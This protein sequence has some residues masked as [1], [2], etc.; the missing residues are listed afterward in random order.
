MDKRSFDPE[1]Y[2]HLAAPVSVLARDFAKDDTSALHSH[3]RCQLIY[4]VSGTMRVSTALSTWIVPPQRALWI[5]P[6]VLHK[7]ERLDP[8]SMRTA[9]I[10]ADRNPFGP[11]ECHM[12]AMSSLVRELILR[13]LEEPQDYV[14]EGPALCAANLLLS[15]L[16]KLRKLD[17]TLPMPQ[18]QRLRR[19]C[20]HLLTMPG[21]DADLAAHAAYAG[22]SPRNLQRLFHR[23]LGM[24]FGKWREQMVLVNAAAMLARGERISTVAAKLNYRSPS[25]F[26]AMFRRANGVSPTAFAAIT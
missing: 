10:A 25:A 16:P 23:E 18:D 11:G 22:T 17:G 9:Y 14:P 2:Q 6:G 15:E 8:V 12:L 7:T 21:G 1:D 20:E 26:A 24:S 13:L 3:P 19:L 4:A 5:A